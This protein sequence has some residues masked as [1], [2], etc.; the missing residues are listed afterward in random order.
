MLKQKPNEVAGDLL[1][2]SFNNLKLSFVDFVID[3]IWSIIETDV[4][5]FG[6]QNESKLTNFK[7]T[8]ILRNYGIDNKVKFDYINN[9][10]VDILNNEEW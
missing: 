10:F 1:T 3:E 6:I 2:N 4:I 7:E 5:I 9:L 8:E